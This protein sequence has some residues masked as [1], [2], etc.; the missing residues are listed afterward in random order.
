VI[1]Q[2]FRHPPAFSLDALIDGGFALR[3]TASAVTE[4]TSPF[5]KPPNQRPANLERMPLFSRVVNPINTHED[6]KK[7]SKLQLVPIS[8]PR[9][10][11]I[12][13]SFRCGFLKAVAPAVFKL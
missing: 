10:S 9:F 4:S 13:F 1:L 6:N 5:G 8:P 2:P 11:A 7:C 12:V 3:Q